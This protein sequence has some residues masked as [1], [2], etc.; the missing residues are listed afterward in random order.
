MPLSGVFDSLTYATTRNT[1]FQANRVDNL[2]IA[3]CFTAKLAWQ[4]GSHGM[5]IP[6]ACRF[7]QHHALLRAFVS[8][9]LV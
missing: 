5:P 2:W 1:I 3:N 8:I 4:A 6:V 9:F 7:F